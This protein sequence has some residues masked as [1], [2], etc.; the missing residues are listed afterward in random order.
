[1][2]KLNIAS[3]QKDKDQLSILNSVREPGIN[4]KM[5]PLQQREV[6]VME[7][8]RVVTV[9]VRGALPLTTCTDLK[10]HAGL[11]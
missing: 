2:K 5:K 7:C 11:Q 9:L 3:V 8:C 1:M 4:K 10:Q 6:G